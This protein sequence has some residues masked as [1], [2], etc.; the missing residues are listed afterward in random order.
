MN[1]FARTLIFFGLIL[2]GMGILAAFFSKIPMLGKLPGDIF[3]R[4]G[5]FTFYFPITTCVLL[6][7]ILTLVLTIFGKR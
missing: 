5:S 1:D 7:L 3:I 2:I 6:S 4:R